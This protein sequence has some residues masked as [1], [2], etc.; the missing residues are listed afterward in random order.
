MA[1]F[2]DSN[3]LKS[4]KENIDF[5]KNVSI[6]VYEFSISKFKPVPSWFGYR[7]KIKSG[8]SSSPLD[9]IR[10]NGWSKEMTE[11]LLKVL[12]VLEMSC[13]KYPSLSDYLERILNAPL[14]MVDDFPAPSAFER[15][16]KV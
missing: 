5:I 7:K 6:E 16:P 4:G 8:K 11:E 14:F 1:N 13:D 12:H 2:N 10:P 9:A 15:K 3:T